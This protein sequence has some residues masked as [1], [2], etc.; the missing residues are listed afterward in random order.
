MIRGAFVVTAA[1]IAIIAMIAASAIEAS[2]DEDESVESTDVYT[3]TY[4]TNGGYMDPYAPDSYVHGSYMPLPMAFREGYLFAGWCTE[5][6]LTNPIGGIPS[7]LAGH[8]ILYAKWVDDDRVGTGWTMKVD[9]SYN[10]GATAVS[11]SVTYRYVYDDDGTIL[12]TTENDIHYRWSEGDSTDDRNLASW[13]TNLTYGFRYAYT[14]RSTDVRLTVWEDQDGNRIWVRDLIVLV[15]IETQ[16]DRDGI[17]TQTLV[18][19]FEFTPDI[20]YTPQVRS[21]YPITVDGIGPAE[22][23]K[24][25]TLTAVGDGFKGWLLNGKLV[26]E[27]RTCTFKHI[28]HCDVITATSDF[29]F[30]TVTHGTEIS[31]LGF[32]GSRIT[33]SD[34]NVVTDLSKLEPGMYTAVKTANGATEVLRFVMEDRKEFSLQWEFEGREYS[35]SITLLY[36]QMA[37]DLYG[38]EYMPRFF[39]KSQS[40]IEAFHSYNDAILRGIASE[41]RSMGVGMDE[42][43]Y[44]EFVL[45]FVQTIPYL[46][47]METRGIEEYWKFPMETLW[48]GGGDCEDKT[49]LYDTLMGICGY[50]VAFVMFK[51]HAMSAV[52]VDG[53]GEVVIV[54]NYTFVMAETTWPQFS[55]GQSSASHLPSDSIYSCRVECFHYENSVRLSPPPGDAVNTSIGI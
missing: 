30:Q 45:R 44:A 27:E 36:S 20:G 28:T 47:D 26:S 53:P 4:R 46:E 42:R 2:E 12:L 19:E 14:D 48:D 55:L 11:G 37:S 33:D 50:R 9:G 52:T 38:N 15:K 7:S 41:L 51:D 22:I 40:H 49:I 17:I 24:D 25:L 39:Q 23:G 13:I 32:G 1:V 16:V 10:N 21:E 43:T 34:G 29:D 54:D 18:D 35:M 5:S 3:I 31:D 6:G 8:V